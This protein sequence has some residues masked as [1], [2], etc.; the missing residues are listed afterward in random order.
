MYAIVDI[1]GKQ[2]KVEE[3]RYL[4]IDLL[5][6]QAGEAITLDRV[7]LIADG[8]KITVGKPVI[9]GAVVEAKVKDSFKDTKVKIF[10]MHKKKGYRLTQGHR[11]QY[12]R[13]QI[14][15][16]VAGIKA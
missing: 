16:I 14:D 1:K 12:T 5:E 8:E 15:K 6:Q 4:E 13:I 9:E 3:G 2:Y 10:K 11:Q 7:L